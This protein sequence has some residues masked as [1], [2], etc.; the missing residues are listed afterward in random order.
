MTAHNRSPDIL[1]VTLRDG[2]YLI[3]FQFTA[4]D[5]A[6]IASAL[7]SAGFRW[8]EVGHGI[9]LNA[10][11]AGMGRAAATD[12]EY[13]EAT[14]Q[15]LK[16][17]HWGMFFI[18]GIGRAE[19]LRLAARYKMAFVRIGT[20]IT[21]IS[22][23]RPFIALAKEL[24][25]VV[26]YN[27]MKSYAVSPAEFAR[28]AAQVHKWG[29]DI[30][31]LVD[32]AG[33]M[34][35]DDIRAYLNA[36][37]SESDVSLG[38]HGH[39]NLSLAMANTL[40]AVESGAAFVDS[41]LQGMGRSAGN[42]ITEVLIA[43]LKKRGFLADIDL[44]AVMD[45]GQGLIQP[46]LRRSGVD[47]MAVTAG[48]ARFHSSYTSKVQNYAKKYQLDVRDLIV[49]LCQEDQVAAPDELLERLSLELAAEK[50]PQVFAIPAFATGDRKKLQSSEALPWLLK[51]IR[52]R[53]VKAGKFSTLNIVI[54]EEPRAEIDV[55]GNI[56]ST[57]SHMVG[58]VTLTSTEQ[59]TS[60]L[61]T[62]DGEVDVIFLDVDHKPFGPHSAAQIARRQLGKSLLLTYLDS[63]VWVNALEDQIV[64]LLGEALDD[65]PLVIAGDHPKSRFLAFRLAERRAE[66]TILGAPEDHAVTS[67]VGA[68]RSLSFDPKH[69]TI[70]HLTID[71]QQTG[72]QLRGARL[73]VVWPSKKAWFGF[74][75]ACPITA[76]TYVLDAGIG[77]I[78]PDA[79]EQARQSG[80]LLIRVN[81]W[82]TLAGALSAA[83]E[84]ARVYQECH[85]WE[86]LA[87]VPVI[88][89]G[90]L[91]QYG[92][93]V[94]DSVHHPTRVIGISDGRGGVLFDY[95]EQEREGV[96]RVSE[97]ISRRILAPR[98]SGDA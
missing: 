63:Q 65:V 17:A 92:D 98:L 2:S 35:P 83:H 1:E 9:G 38:F 33:G 26:S 4:E 97:E 14:A 23:A 77:S 52:P 58:S 62:A 57:Q 71:S 22:E 49:R 10:S 8:I 53:A 34:Y 51:Q 41:S 40:C 82:P 89:G 16:V 7:E 72:N 28:C 86:Q 69:F 81:L 90:A 5:T 43:I 30:A 87:G 94:V 46:L 19:D 75:Q 12:E 88:A 44:K 80:A 68:M 56:Q 45:I 39:D 11:A 96:R 18:P 37:R 93:V 67:D 13:L 55:S 78:L 32:S 66:V 3:D 64:R 6:T 15:A 27:A 60:V 84:S 47:P 79:Q 95:G 59:L 91:G 74:E 24:G 70:N 54:G 36:A 50:M 21:E 73:V 31:C 61:A 85:G 42:A 48:Y 29:A 25:M 76:G 20:N